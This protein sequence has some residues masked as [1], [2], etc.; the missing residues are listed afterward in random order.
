[1]RKRMGAAA[2]T[3]TETMTW[4][5]VCDRLLQTYHALV[6]NSTLIDVPLWQQAL[7]NP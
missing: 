5:T 3:H 1:L 6:K 7:T 2:R 4:E